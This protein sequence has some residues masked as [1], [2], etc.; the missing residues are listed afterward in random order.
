MSEPIP[1][2]RLVLVPVA[3]STA[4]AVVS[5]DLSGLRVGDGWPHEDSLDG[6]RMTA[7][8]TAS[9][10][11]VTLEGVVIGDCGTHG[12]PDDR[13]DVEI[14]FGLAAPSRGRGY[15]TEVVAGLSQWLLRQPGVR[16]VV[17]REVPADNLPSRRALERAG[18]VV[19]LSDER[20]V[21]Y[22]LAPQAR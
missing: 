6:L 4:R 17:A 11:F 21:W 19:E 18:F 22:A 12:P 3:P 14:G 15:G 13:G 1:T 8:R 9:C 2:R 16:R 20:R 10:W 7:E 5:G